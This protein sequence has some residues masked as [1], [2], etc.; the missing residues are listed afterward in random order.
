MRAFLVVCIFAI[1]GCA[2]QRGYSPA[3]IPDHGTVVFV[4]DGAGDFRVSSA[5]FRGVLADMGWP[6]HVETVPW[7][8]GYMRIL[9]DQLDYA[10]GRTEGNQLA[11]QIMALKVT[12]PDRKVYLAGH[13]AGTVVIIAAA[14]SLP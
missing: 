6:V 7:S 1:A 10:H 3:P 5:A 12:R 4:A 9:R 2:L 13:S 8:H 11:A 14:E